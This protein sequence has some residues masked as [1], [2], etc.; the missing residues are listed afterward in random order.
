MRTLTDTVRGQE[1]RMSD[2]ELRQ[3]LESAHMPTLQAAL[4][5]M[6]ADRRWI[7]GDFKARRDKSIDNGSAWLPPEVKAR[8]LNEAVP[9]I[10]RARENGTARI[11]GHD[12]V[13]I[14]SSVLGQNVPADEAGLLA[15]ELGVLSRDVDITVP[16]GRRL[17]AVVVG[18]GLSGICAAIRLK[19]AG[20]EFVVLEKNPAPGGTWFE[21]TYPGCG[22][23][24]PV[25][26]YSFSFAQRPSWSSYFAKQ[27]ELHK[28]FDELIDEHRIG[29]HFRYD[30]YVE[31]ASYDE[32]SAIW[33]VSARSGEGACQ[34]F[35]AELLIV[36][37]GQINQPL[38]PPIPGTADFAGP[39]VHT[40][41][42]PSDLSVEDKEVVVVGTGA[43][44]MQL[45]PA[46]AGKARHVTVVQRSPQWAFPNLLYHQ[47]VP[48]EVRRLMAYVPGYLNW[49]RLRLMWLFGDRG[50]AALQVDPQWPHQSRSISEINERHR[51]QLTSYIEEQL[52]DRPDLMEVSLP[53]YPVFGKRPLIDNRWYETI[54]RD[55]V[56][57]VP[58]TV[59]RMDA[60]GA[61]VGERHV[62]ADVIVLAT[63]FKVVDMIS[64]L[65]VQGRDGRTLADA[66]AED[67]ARAHRGVTV[68]GFPN[69]FLLFGPNTNS[70]HG[71]SQMLSAELQMRYVMGL[72]KGM[73]DRDLVEVEP[74]SAAFDVYNAELDAALAR[75]VWAHRGMTTYYRND[76]GRVVAAIPW[77]NAQYRE[78]LLEPDW[79]E[80]RCRSSADV[81][82]R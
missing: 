16:Q 76:R 65:A 62:D 58:G 40:A 42:W 36:A 34:V 64:T 71:G 19:A 79:S 27:P 56:T 39:V 1:D 28:Y 48:P 43:S 45:V 29:A 60:G 15:E 31:S 51:V 26:L 78:M 50:H 3:L 80:Y 52:K 55:D 2:E 74:T 25:H 82:T 30:T 61:W 59:T 12:V 13:A 54:K 73:I 4:V 49:Y 47:Q 20:I 41:E 70:A 21:N 32:S 53:D 44:A 23:D 46:I 68:P 77:T 63:G 6:T 38:K 69:L 67:G 9:A 14:L 81:G 57:L 24:S 66:W 17:R 35:E 11:D 72:V 75:T 33:S 7:E 5:H 22:V 37:V 18:G 8:L 10:Q